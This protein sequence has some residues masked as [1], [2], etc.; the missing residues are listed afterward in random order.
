[1]MFKSVE[2]NCLPFVPS[3]ALH[4]RPDRPAIEPLTR[5][6]DEPKFSAISIQLISSAILSNAIE[7]QEE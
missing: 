4:Q 1:M 2:R 5:L 3:T 7:Q 6:V